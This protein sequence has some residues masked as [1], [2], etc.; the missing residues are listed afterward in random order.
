MK[1]LQNKINYLG[2]VLFLLYIGTDWLSAQEPDNQPQKKGS[3]EK[4]KISLRDT[5]D[6]A[7]D[8]SNFLDQPEGILPVPI[9]IT[10]PAIGY[11]GGLAIVMIKENKGSS[12]IRRLPP[13]I[14]GALGFGTQNKTWGAGIFHF[15]SFNKD[16]IRYLGA[17][18]KPTINIKYYGNR[19]EDAGLGPVLLKM[20]AWAVYNRV[21]FR[22]SNSNI[23]IGPEYTFFHTKISF[24]SLLNRPTIPSINTVDGKSTISMLG[25]LLSYDSRD[26]IFTP[27][28]GFL[29]G[30]ITR[31]SAT[32]LGSSN[33]YWMLNPYVMAWVPITKK[34]FSAY[35]FDSQ[36]ALGDAP[37]YA[38]P[39]VSMRG[40]PAMKYQGEITMV[41][42]TEWRGFVYR[43][44]SLVGFAGTGKAFDQFNEFSDAEWVYSYGTGFRYQLARKYGMHAGIDF[45]WSNEDFGFYLVLGTAWRK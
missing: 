29:A 1:R 15:Q 30:V 44:W 27:N 25:L 10:E 28:K 36:F 40:V 12:E 18:I 26:Y 38:D 2:V 33:E 24:D 19:M 31:Y 43:R 4:V 35:R 45:A 42:E 20:D 22:I 11:G 5:L 8:I 13:T 6:G 39:F 16:K 34:V 14:S 32:F 9:I 7:F 3:K 17:F 41:L 37:F 23:F 21:Q